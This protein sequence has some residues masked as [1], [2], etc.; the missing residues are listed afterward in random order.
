[1]RTGEPRI[2]QIAAKSDPRSPRAVGV[3]E[4]EAAVRETGIVPGAVLLKFRGIV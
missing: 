4:I 2:V 1:M 3:G